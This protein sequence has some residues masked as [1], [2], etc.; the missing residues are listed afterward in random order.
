MCWGVSLESDTFLIKVIKTLENVR[1]QKYKNIYQ[2][3]FTVEALYG[4]GSQKG[5]MK[6]LGSTQQAT[7]LPY[8]HALLS[9]TWK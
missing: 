6:P 4:T 8:P 9:K 5:Y 3:Q 1:A 7:F 2:L